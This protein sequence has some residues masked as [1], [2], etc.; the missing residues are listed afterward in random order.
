MAVRLLVWECKCKY[1]YRWHV[2]FK[3][4]FIFFHPYLLILLVEI[5]CPRSKYLAAWQ[6]DQWMLYFWHFH[7]WI[8]CKFLLSGKG[9]TN[10]CLLFL[11]FLFFTTVFFN[12]RDS[13]GFI[14]YRYTCDAF[15]ALENG[16]TLRRS[17]EPDFELYFCGRK[18]FCK[19]NY[20]DLGRYLALCEL[21]CTTET[22]L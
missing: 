15:A 11:A 22:M 14:T 17:N 1:C 19:S 9:Y 5:S 18:Q 8:S 16:Y 6:D 21:K 2:E 10:V 13:Y 20:A 12:Y 7:C 3:T 4:I